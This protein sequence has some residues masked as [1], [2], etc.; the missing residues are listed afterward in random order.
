MPSPGRHGRL[1]VHHAEII[2]V[3]ASP[4]A[5]EDLRTELTNE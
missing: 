3:A 5:L 2:N 4:T 1:F